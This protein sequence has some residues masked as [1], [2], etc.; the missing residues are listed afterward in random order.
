MNN[1]KSLNTIGLALGLI[2]VII[3]FI[4]GPPQPILEEGIKL[5]LEDNTPIDDNGK[6]VKEHN[7]ETTKKDITKQKHC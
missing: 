4:W 6:T 1:S 5:G 3:I 2:G 7:E